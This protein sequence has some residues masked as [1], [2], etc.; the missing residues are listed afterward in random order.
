MLPTWYYAQAITTYAITGSAFILNYL[1]AQ[2]RAVKDAMGTV[3]QTIN[4]YETAAIVSLFTMIF[5]PALTAVKLAQQRTLHVGTAGAADMSGT[6]LAE[7]V[8]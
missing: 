2:N 1:S 7:R 8:G 6:P 5:I 3:W 4:I